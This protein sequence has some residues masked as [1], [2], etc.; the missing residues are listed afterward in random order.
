MYVS[1]TLRDN[2]D[3]H[4]DKVLQLIKDAGFSY[5]AIGVFGSYARGRY[6][7]MQV[8]LGQRL[9][10]SHKIILIQ[11]FHILHQI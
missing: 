6:V 5:N 3:K 10:L 7:M 8:S 11:M 9:F 1:N 4:A 2:F